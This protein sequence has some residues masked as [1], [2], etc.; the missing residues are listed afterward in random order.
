MPHIGAERPDE[1]G[2][3]LI[4][5]WIAGMKGPAPRGSPD[6][7][8]PPD[9]LLAEAKS[10]MLIARKLGRGEAGT[11]ERGPLLAAAAKLSPGPI[12]DLFEGYLPQEENGVRKLG[13]NP[14]PRAILALAGDSARGEKLFW[15]EAL[16][17]G[18]CHKIGD[19]GTEIG[20]DLT[21]IGKLRTR[22]DLLQSILEP[23]RRIEPKYAAYVAQT[24]DGR[25]LTGLLVKRDENEVVLRD[26]ENKLT[27]LRAMNVETLR[28][29]RMS[30]MP[31]GQLAGLTLQE[32]ADLLEYVANRK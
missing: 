19:R 18:S 17:C 20:P 2:L 27:I 25:S 4:E 9:K 16:K 15:S 10:A 14:R 32:A 28:P 31:D 3:Q 30:L 5:H 1:A 13:S 23:S 24:A 21:S 7:L 12:R 11:A 6:L 26:G 8:A 22:D 29:A